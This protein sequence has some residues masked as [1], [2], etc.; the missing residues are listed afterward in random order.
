MRLPPI[1]AFTRTSDTGIRNVL[2]SPV[3]VVDPLTGR[4]TADPI[5]AIW[6]TGATLTGIT[7]RIVDTLKLQCTTYIFMKGVHGEPKRTPAYPIS[8]ILHN[9]VRINKIVAGLIEIDSA[10]V[11]IGMDIIN[12]GDFAVTNVG[13]VTQFF[14]AFHL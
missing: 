2:S 6:D 8:L 12:I 9:D 5:S 3:K 10:D 11:L 7:Q 4:V 1:H 13:G 14:S